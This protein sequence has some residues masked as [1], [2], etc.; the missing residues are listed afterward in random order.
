LEKSNKKSKTFD[1]LT[2]KGE[3]G[4]VPDCNEEN[5]LAKFLAKSPIL[6]AKIVL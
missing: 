6:I 5:S 4:K 3:R 1:Q 2:G